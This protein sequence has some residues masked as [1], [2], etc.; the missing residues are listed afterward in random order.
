MGIVRLSLR[1][2]SKSDVK[3]KG[4]VFRFFVHRTGNDERDK[5]WDDR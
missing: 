5:T 3:A 1:L 2:K 4:S